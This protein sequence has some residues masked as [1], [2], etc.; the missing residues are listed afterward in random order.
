MAWQ[1]IITLTSMVSQEDYV[2]TEDRWGD[3]RTSRASTAYQRDAEAAYCAA[4][5]RWLRVRAKQ[6][7]GGRHYQQLLLKDKF[8]SF[9]ST[10]DAFSC[11][12][13]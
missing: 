11:K 8:T 10:S 2:T 5:T 7:K 13:R 4:R 6:N 3:V 9:S 12:E 1:G